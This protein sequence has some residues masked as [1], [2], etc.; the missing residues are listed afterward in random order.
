MRS[1]GREIFVDY[2][3]QTSLSSDIL[4]YIATV[5]IIYTTMLKYQTTDMSVS[6]NTDQQLPVMVSVRF[7]TVDCLSSRMTFFSVMHKMYQST[8]I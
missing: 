3:T 4:G 5:N 7:T 6:R 8:E 1:R 2:E